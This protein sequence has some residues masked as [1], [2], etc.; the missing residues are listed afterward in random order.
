MSNKKLPLYS[1]ESSQHRSLVDDI[2]QLIQR[3]QRRVAA[4]VN[5]TVVLLY[6]T[7]GKRINDEILI[8]KSE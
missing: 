8:D 5:A 3:G 7:I 4:E 1:I 2:A 6:W